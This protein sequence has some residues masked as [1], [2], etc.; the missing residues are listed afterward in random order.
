[1]DGAGSYQVWRSTVEGEQGYVIGMTDELE[2]VDTTAL[3]NVIYWYGVTARSTTSNG[4][5]DL[6]EQAEGYIEG[7]PLPDPPLPPDGLLLV[8]ISP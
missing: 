3:L 5:S 1:V 7:A 8:I 6:S 4:C 2:L